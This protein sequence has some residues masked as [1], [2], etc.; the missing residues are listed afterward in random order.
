MFVGGWYI[1][2]GILHLI[3]STFSSYQFIRSISSIQ[4]LQYLHRSIHPLSNTKSSTSPVINPPKWSPSPS[5]LPSQLSQL[6]LWSQLHRL[7]PANPSLPPSSSKRKSSAATSPRTVSSPL[8]GI[9][10]P[11]AMMS[12]SLLTL[13]IHHLPK[14]S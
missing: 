1:S 5:S 8:H 3:S 6:P 11:E 7:P 9:H 2:K 14:L 4:S 10:M 12:P 13:P